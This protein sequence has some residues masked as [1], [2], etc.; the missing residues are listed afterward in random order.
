MEMLSGLS[1][2]FVIAVGS[3]LF[4]MIRILNEYERAVIFTLGRLT[5]AKGPGLIVLIPGIQKMRRVD[6]RTITMDVPP[7]DIITKDN[8]TIKV[9]AVLYF[10]VVEPNRAVIEVENYLLATSKLAQT[11]LRSVV[12]QVEL[13]TV[14]TSRDAINKKLQEILDLQ[15]EP[16]GVKVSNVEVKQVDLPIE[17][18]RAM[19]Q[20]AEAERER[21]A[22]VIKAEG[23]QQASTKLADAARILSAQPE[24]LQ[25]RYLQTILEMSS[26]KTSTIILPLPMELMR[27]MMRKDS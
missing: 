16:W 12:G 23:E 10:R 13:D 17:M 25:L 7:Q 27:G 24:S 21:R 15:T 2:F 18:Q 20:Q 5:G 14:L 1:L 22:K 11:T 9:N 26:E 3:V 4:S 6:L 19:A 8:V